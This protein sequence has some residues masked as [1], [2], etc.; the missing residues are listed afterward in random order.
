[1]SSSTPA[2]SELD[3]YDFD[4]PRELIAQ[5][6]LAQRVDSR[7]MVIHRDTRTIEHAHV[8][9]LPDYLKSGDTLVVN[10]SKV[11]PAR[12][13]GRR[14]LT[15][16]RWEGLFLRQDDSGVAELLCKTRGSMEIGETITIND[17][18]GRDQGRLVFLG[19]GEQGRMLLRPESPEPWFTLLDRCGRVPLP[20]YIRD[21]QMVDDDKK[22]Y[23]TVYARVAGSVAAPTAGLHFT[24]ELIQRTRSAGM[25]LV[26]V[27]LH[28]G[29]GTFR[30]IQVDR[31]DEHRMHSEY[32]EITGPV[33]KRLQLT[34]SEGG[35]IIA[36]GTTS[37]RVLE[38]AAAH[39]KTQSPDL[40]I[41]EWSGETD[42]FIKPGHQF[43]AVDGL[44]TN[45][46]LPKSSLIV[47]VSAFAGHQLVM[48]AYREAIA[49]RYRFYSYGD[50]MLIL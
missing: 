7:M 8:R 40:V 49:E 14:T 36:V 10:D 47:L 37:V 16:G 32:G 43:Q 30:P 26:A 41:D 4:L 22:R 18:E 50:C 28:V 27:T 31:L 21:G 39:A 44:L 11:I 2:A 5:E 24:P 9:D 46:H 13:I 1:M 38:T 42:I 34:R 20:P 48:K 3:Q 15:G 23:Q 19:H 29:I 6:P 17:L 12:L 45:F 25:A 33:A 35:R